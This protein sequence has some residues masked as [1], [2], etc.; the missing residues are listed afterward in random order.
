V[1]GI[2]KK[3]RARKGRVEMGRG[4]GGG[5]LKRRG[6]REVKKREKEVRL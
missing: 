1:R 3:R 6:G 5:R 2:E 4:K